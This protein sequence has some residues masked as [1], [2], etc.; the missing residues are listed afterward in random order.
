MSTPLQSFMEGAQWAQRRRLQQQDLQFRQDQQALAAAQSGF[1][2]AD[3]G[4]YAPRPG[5]EQDLLAQQVNLLKQNFESLQ[6]EMLQKETWN[7]VE[8]GIQDGNYSQFNAMLGANQ[9]LKDLYAQQGIQSIETFDPYNDNHLNA[10]QK[11]GVNP[12]VIEYLKQ[13]RDGQIEGMDEQDVREMAKSI[14]VAY[15]LVRQT[16]NNLNVVQLENFVGTTGLLRRAQ[17]E[18]KRKAYFDAIAQG[19]NALKGITDRAYM[20][21]VQKT[22]AQTALQQAQAGKLLTDVK[23][24]ELKLEDMQNFLKNNPEATLAD[25]LET[26]KPEKK[27]VFQH[28]VEYLR[29]NFG[30]DIARQYIAKQIQQP[31]KT[32]GA[33][34]TEQAKVGQINDIKQEAGV[35][36][37]HEV[38][39]ANLS[40]DNLTRFNSLAM[41][42][43]KEVKD[44]ER[45]AIASLS[46]AADKLNVDDLA[47]TT[48]ILDATAKSAADRLGMDLSDEVLVQSAN[49]NLIVN[50][51]IKAAMGSQVTGNELDRIN[52]QLG[53]EFRADKTVRIKMAETLDNIVAK[54]DI[55]KTVAPAYYA[56][57]IKN[58]TANMTKMANYLRNNGEEPQEQVQRPT[59]RPTQR[60]PLSAGQIVGGM[61]FKGGDPKD[62]NNWER[63]N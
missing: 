17:G 1:Q 23:T 14:G 49:Y 16:D 10:Y 60:R 63:G 44:E 29:S 35:N 22:E 24:S 36:E 52:R 3:D 57:E 33:I 11:V 21:N 42:Q 2:R 54:F 40:G 61:R 13:A 6:K 53:T 58:R 26:T 27:S 5:S 8:A 50:A 9:G 30:E 38:D 55:Y 18:Q 15:P 62:P 51:I 31:D 20:A 43:A 12:D 46:A 34:R 25:Y 4:T 59:T 19:Q 47:E 45:S 56:K 39:V 41:E 7:A 32:P 48:G 28:N 37:L